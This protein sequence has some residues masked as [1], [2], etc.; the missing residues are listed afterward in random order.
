MIRSSFVR[1]RRLM[2]RTPLAAAVL[3]GLIAD[4]APAR[5]VWAPET[6]PYERSGWGIKP[7]AIVVGNSVCT[8]YPSQLKWRTWGGSVAT[9]RGKVLDPSRGSGESCGRW[10]RASVRTPRRFVLTGFAA[11]RAAGS[12]RI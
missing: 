1:R 9:A 12:T 2:R 11:A 7:K 6:T 3:F 5:T 8:V 10:R 4:A